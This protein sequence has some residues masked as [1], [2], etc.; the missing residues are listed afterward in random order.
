MI[1]PIASDRDDVLGFRLTGKLHAADY[2]N[3][4]P[5]VDAALEAHDKISLLVLFH[6]FEGWDMAA[7]WED[8]KFDVTHFTKFQRIALVGEKRWEKWMAAFCKPFTTAKVRYFN[9][10][11]LDEARHWVEQGATTSAR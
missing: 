4:V 6:D 1:E 5:I 9:A 3:L 8:T 10:A 7:L 2:E 11:Q